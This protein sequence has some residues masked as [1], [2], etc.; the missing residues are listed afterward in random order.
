[1]SWPAMIVLIVLIS[2][3]AAVFKAKYRFDG[4]FERRD[5]DSPQADARLMADEIR[6]L[7]D[8]VAVLERIAT[9]GEGPAKL[10][11]EIERLRKID[12]EI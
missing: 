1:M 7:R 12:R 2:S 6:R 5:V 11:R 9:D 10:D 8:R 4:S 3:I